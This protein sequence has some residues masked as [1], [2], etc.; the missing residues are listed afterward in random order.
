MVQTTSTNEEKVRV[1]FSP[2]TAMGHDA[3]IENV[4]FKVDSGDA[5]VEEIE[6]NKSYY[7][8]SGTGGLNTITVNADADMG[9][10]YSEI[11]ETIEYFVVEAQATS[12]GV[13][14]GTPEPK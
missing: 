2:K 5:T 8:I 11:S 9:E 7:L 3:P 1:E 13:S 10:G 6:A 4:V 14:I 12:L